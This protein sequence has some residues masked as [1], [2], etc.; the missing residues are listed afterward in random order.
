M[1]SQKAVLLG[2]WM[3][4]RWQ[5]EKRVISTQFE[6]ETTPPKYQDLEQKQINVFFYLQGALTKW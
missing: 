6:E 2:N 3:D 1:H 4:K 5:S